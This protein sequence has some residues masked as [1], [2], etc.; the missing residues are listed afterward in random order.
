V[1]EYQH[2]QHGDDHARNVENRFAF[3]GRIRWD[4]LELRS[5]TLQPQDT[6]MKKKKEGLWPSLSHVAGFRHP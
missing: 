5:F 6:T 4:G 1:N 3:H 2:R